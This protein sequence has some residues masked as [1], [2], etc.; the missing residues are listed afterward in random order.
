MNRTG[1][2]HLKI[3]KIKIIF[4][5]LLLFSISCNGQTSYQKRKTDTFIKGDSVKELGSS[6]MVV[7]QDKH[8]I[9]WFG[10]W[11]TGVYRYDAHLQDWQEKTLIN[12]TTKHGLANNRV[13]EIKEDS[14]GNIYFISCYPQSSVV[15]FDGKVFTT[16]TATPS[17]DWKL[18]SND[19]WFRNAY[20]TEKVLRF[21]GNTLFELQ[22]PKPPDLSNPFEI[23]SIY[24]DQKGNIWFGTNP[25]GV[26]RYNGK[27]FDWITEED[28]TEFRNEGANGVRSITED[29]NG[30]FW[31]N[32]ENRYSV[33]D[34]ITVKNN[35]FYTRHE[36]IGSLDEKKESNLDEYLSTVKDNQNNL[37]FVTYRDGVWK[38]DTHLQDKKGTKITHYPVQEN[39]KNITLF[40]IYKD[41]NGDLWL[42]THE[43]GVYTFNGTKFEKFKP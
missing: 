24:K 13:D 32:T 22:L 29:K 10:S 20:Q 3:M 27:S 28:V 43:N 2:N 39:G 8:N 16:L 18:Q 21:D 41:N 37:W 23:Y 42:G 5:S 38:Y 31:F 1:K 12:Y 34:S 11:E 40:S 4:L 9:Y 36:S 17:K 30:D 19:L 25:V 26:C 15:K 14:A 7:Y 6:I 35:T 33:Y